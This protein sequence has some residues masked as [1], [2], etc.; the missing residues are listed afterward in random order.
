MNRGLATG[1]AILV[2]AIALW[3]GNSVV[4][5]AA[6]VGDVPPVALNF[7]RW[8]VALAIFLPFTARRVWRQRRAFAEHW[9]YYLAFGIVSVG[10]FNIFFYAGLQYT[11]AVQGSLIQS[12]LPVLVLMLGAVFVRQRISGRQIGGVV[13]SIAG[14]AVVVARGDMEI[15]RTLRPNVGDL[16]CLLAVAF[17]SIQTFILRWKPPAVDMPSFMTVVIAVGL[18]FN[19]PLLAWEMAAGRTMPVTAETVAGIVYLALFASVI[20]STMYNTGVVMVGPATAGYFGNLF[21]IF[22]AVLAIVLLDETLAW[23]HVAGGG[24]ILGG[25]YLATVARG[26]VAA[27]GEGTV[28][29]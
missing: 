12:V 17:W 16:W 6:M 8:T 7:W 9:W 28:R 2:I 13:L 20:A 19:V 18:L 29:R 15:L 11:T 26:L 4:G 21:P 22:S 5:R 27:D 1:Y 25:I 24:L 23:F 3:S 10:C 14:A